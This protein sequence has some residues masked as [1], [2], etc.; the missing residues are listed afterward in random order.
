[1]AGGVVRVEF[2]GTW[3]AALRELGVITAEEIPATARARWVEPGGDRR[4]E[5]VFIGIGLEAAAWQTAL[6]ECLT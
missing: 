5:L 1:V 4:Q 3:V 6:T 2:I